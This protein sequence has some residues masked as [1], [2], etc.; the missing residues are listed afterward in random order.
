LEVIYE[1]P[2]MAVLKSQSTKKTPT[3]FWKAI[4]ILK[5]DYG[6]NLDKLVIKGIGSEMNPEIYYGVM[7]KPS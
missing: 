7:F 4:D 1:S 5:R 2:N 6:F 3:D